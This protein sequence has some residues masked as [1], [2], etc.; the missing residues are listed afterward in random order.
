MARL[1]ESDLKGL[2]AFLRTSESYPDVQSFRAGTLPALR[3]LLP[4]DSVAY[5]EVDPVRRET[6]WRLEPE[7]YEPAADREAFERWVHQHPIVA[8][9][10][11]VHDGKA[12]KLSDFLTR[13]ELHRREIYHEFFRPL[14]IEYQMVITVPVPGNLLLGVPFN[15]KRGDFS[16]RERLLLDLLRPHL[17]QAYRHAEARTSMRRLLEAL[18]SGN[19]S[20]VVLL[21]SS[22]GVQL[23]TTRARTLLGSYFGASG[24]SHLPERLSDWVRAGPARDLVV[25][26]EGGRLRVTYL[27]GC[28]GERDA[29]LLDERAGPPSA[30]AL[31]SLGLTRRQAE[32]LAL[33]ARGDTDAQAAARLGVSPRT[34]DKHLERVYRALGVTT[35]TAAVARA[36]EITSGR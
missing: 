12:A 20:A 14:E 34:V 11:R 8:H 2:L 22:G 10:A 28:D 35:R 16:E 32:V 31:E 15:R 3:E 19:G 13:R 18:D 27:A 6:S 33:V 17:V 9:T 4:C 1:S 7:S 21:N 30:P 25:G 29:L 26:G 24:D 36:F 5:N 23:A